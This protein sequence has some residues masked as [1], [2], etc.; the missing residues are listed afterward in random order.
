[1]ASCVKNHEGG[2]IQNDSI[3]DH[4]QPFSPPPDVRFVRVSLPLGGILP[5][6]ENHVQDP[7]VE[8]AIRFAKGAVQDIHVGE[9]TR[10]IEEE[11]EL[12]FAQRPRR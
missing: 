9:A 4:T 5:L 2:Q 11:V 1:M 6:V 10:K 3:L 7:L 12:F 8:F